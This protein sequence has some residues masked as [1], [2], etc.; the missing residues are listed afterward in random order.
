[1]LTI[2]QITTPRD[3]ADAAELV[4]ELTDWAISLD[5]A[6]ADAPAFDTLETELAGLPGPYAPPSGC[7]LLARENDTP[8]GCIAFC[9][10]GPNTVEVKR[11]YMRPNQ[12]GKGTG[13]QM[14]LRLVDEA[15]RI[16]VRH[17]V[18]DSHR[19]MT[20]AHHLYRSVGFRDVAAPA[21]FP[22]EFVDK[23]VFMQMELS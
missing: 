22:A 17:I 4:R 13:R 11:M 20:A 8:V 7:F 3:K 19:S 14:V 21:G 9:A 10:H 23:V 16:G 2:D 5:P 6:T 1:M 18:L 12:R 15:R